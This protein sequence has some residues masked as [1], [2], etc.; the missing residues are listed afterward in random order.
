MRRFRV[1]AEGLVL[2]GVAT[3]FVWKLT[4]QSEDQPL[5]PAQARSTDQ[6][7]AHAMLSLPSSTKSSS[8]DLLSVF[9]PQR[10]FEGLTLYPISGNARVDLLDFDGRRLHSWAVDADRALLLPNGNLLVLHGSKWGRARRPWRDKRDTVTEYSWDGKV[11]W[12]YKANGNLH[13]DLQ[14]LPNGNTLLLKKTLVPTEFKDQIVDA[15][16]RTIDIKG[17]SVIEIDPAGQIVW[18]WHSHEHLDLNYCGPKGCRYLAGST[19]TLKEASDWTHMNTLQLVPE[20]RWFDGGDTR[21]RPGNLI[22]LARNFSTVYVVD[23]QRGEIVWQYRGDYRGGLGG[24]HDAQMIPKGLPGAGNMLIFDNGAGT[25]NKESV[26]LELT[27]PT[28][29]IAWKYEDSTR[30]FS[31][32]RSA[33]QRLPNGNTLI[34]EDNSG[35]VFEVTPEMDT[36]WEYRGKLPCSRAKRYRRTDCVPCRVL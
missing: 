22:L 30:F 11:V 16:R 25:H 36:V 9:D 17:D 6:P 33:V 31:R 24:G 2:L 5:L 20:N 21:F 3:L 19:R 27:P 12:S 28:K 15:Q 14:R 13:H 26:I 10:A 23:R 34:S 18:Q 32:S 7:M 4:P 29:R 35:R 8:S 1:F